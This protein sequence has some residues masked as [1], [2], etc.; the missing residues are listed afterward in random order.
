MVTEAKKS[1]NQSS[2]SLKN[3]KAGGI[4]Q[5]ESEGLRTQGPLVKV[6]ESQ[7]PRTRSSDVQWQEKMA[8]PAQQRENSLFFGLI[9]PFRYSVDWMM[10]A[11]I[12][13]G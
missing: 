12:G 7:G 8:I 11:H 6:P 4:I 1:N 3:T 9:V 13:E 5:T 2:A 10:P